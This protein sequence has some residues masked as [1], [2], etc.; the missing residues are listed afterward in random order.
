MRRAAHGH[1]AGGK[2][3]PTYA[4]WRNM[5]KRCTNPKDNAYSEYGGRGIRVCK[6]WLRSFTAFL[7]DMGER[8]AGTTLDRID[9]NKHYT[10]SNCRWSD[11]ATQNANKR[12]PWW[13]EGR[14]PSQRWL[15]GAP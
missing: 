15:D 6:R 2:T 13:I 1:R 14:E 3:S 5:I 7:R 8:P 12:A 4:S 10:P 11:Y 9:V